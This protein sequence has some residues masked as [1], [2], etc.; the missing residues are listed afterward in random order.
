M[1]KHLYSTFIGSLIFVLLYPGCTNA[2]G[3]TLVDFGDSPTTTTFGLAGWN[4]I[5]KSN[6]IDYTS[7]GNGGLIITTESEEYDEYRGISGTSRNFS[8]GER[9]VVTWYE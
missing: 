9:I 5:L 1:K 2:Q 8:M 3:I 7:Q 6:N 4:T